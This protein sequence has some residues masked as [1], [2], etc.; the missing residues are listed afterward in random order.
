MAHYDLYSSLGLDRGMDP[1]A[2]SAELD[3]RISSGITTNPGGMEELDIAKRILGN[4]TKRG[5]YDAKLADLQA[6][7]VN[8]VALRELANAD[9]GEA[10]APTAAAA[11]PGGDFSAPGATGAAAASGA[12]AQPAGSTSVKAREKF[13][14]YSQQA[15]QKLSPVLSSAK[16]EVARSSKPVIIGTALVTLAAVLLVLGIYALATRD[17]DAVKVKKSANQFLSLVDERETMDWLRDNADAESLDS[18][19]STLEIGDGFRGVD[20]AVEASDPEV[21]RVIDA[22]EYFSAFVLDPETFGDELAREGFDALYLVRVKNGDDRPANALLIYGIRDKQPVL[23]DLDNQL[24][25]DAA[26]FFGFDF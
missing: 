12:H 17:W 4:P 2:I 8:I 15:Q 21:D 7:D 20:R 3:R 5:M 6:A 10:A 25:A 16:T 13:T 9:F 14:Q 11:A 22:Q 18:I 1:S 23:I 24:V 26:G 19:E